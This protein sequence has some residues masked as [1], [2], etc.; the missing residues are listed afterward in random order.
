MAFRSRLPQL[1]PLAMP[2]Q[3][4]ITACLCFKYWRMVNVGFQPSKLTRSFVN[5]DCN[6]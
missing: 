1:G 5:H 4:L 2:S 3:T 6:H